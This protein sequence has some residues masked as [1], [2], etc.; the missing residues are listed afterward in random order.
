MELKD[1]KKDNYYYA[2]YN[3]KISR[4]IK[5]INDSNFRNSPGV[6]EGWGPGFTGRSVCFFFNNSWS[7]NQNIRL[8]TPEEKHWL[9]CC[10]K[11]NKYISKEEALKTFNNNSLVGRYLKIIK[12]GWFGS[13]F[14]LGDYLKILEDNFKES[15]IKIEKYDN[16]S[17]AI[18]ETNTYTELMPIG[19]NPN[20]IVSEYVECIKVPL[21]WSVF[22]KING[23]YKTDTLGYAKGKYR[24]VFKDGSGQTTNMYEDHF[25]PSTKEAYDNQFKANSNFEIGKW[26]KWDKYYD[27]PGSLKY[28]KPFYL[29]NNRKENKLQISERI[30]DRY[31]DIP[32]YVSDQL[33]KE[34]ILLKD[35]TEIQQYLPDGHPDKIVKK[36]NSFKIGDWVKIIKS[37]YTNYTGLSVGDKFQIEEITAG[38]TIYDKYLRPTR[39]KP[40][41]QQSYCELIT[42]DNP[43]KCSEGILEMIEDNSSQRIP[44]SIMTGIQGMDYFNNIKWETFQKNVVYDKLTCFGPSKLKRVKKSNKISTKTSKIT[45]I[46]NQLKTK[47]NVKNTSKI[48]R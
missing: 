5:P 34:G 7:C 28:F 33:I 1:V 29:N 16:F 46:N 2:E 21:G 26:Y 30:T 11:E 27:S 9:Y 19:F 44:F 42:S 37:D 22:I 48:V 15:C 6:G 39:G 25:I 18:F 10:I 12:T 36:N 31:Y 43:I 20:E 47:T 14:K 23:I 13:A 24:I 40:G 45:K 38:D 17:R 8:A 35:L 41:I 3:D 32:S 4:I